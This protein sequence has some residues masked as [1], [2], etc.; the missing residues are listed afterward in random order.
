[1]NREH[2]GMWHLVDAVEEVVPAI[3]R[4]P[5]WREDARSLAVVR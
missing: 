5:R 2:L 1:M 3:R 4:I